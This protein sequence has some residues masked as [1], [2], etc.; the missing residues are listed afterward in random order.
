MKIYIKSNTNR[1]QHILDMLV[2]GNKLWNPFTGE[3][4]TL[5]EERLAELRNPKPDLLQGLEPT[6][7]YRYDAGKLYYISQ[8]GEAPSGDRV[9]RNADRYKIYLNSF[10]DAALPY[11]RLLVADTT[12]GKVFTR[13]VTQGLSDFKR[14]IQELVEW[15]RDGNTIE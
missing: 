13:E 4:D 7:R 8:A 3:Y 5:S 15:L 14:D 1:N 6:S 9:Y 12:T 2:D 10:A 11:S